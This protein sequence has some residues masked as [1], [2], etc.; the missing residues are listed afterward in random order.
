MRVKFIFTAVLICLCIGGC[1][2]SARQEQVKKNRHRIDTVPGMIEYLKGRHLPALQNVESWQNEYGPGLKLTTE[3]YEVYTTLLE[4]LMLSQVP[5]FVESC[6]R[7]YNDQ[8]LEP[9]ETQFKFTVYLF[10]KREQWESFTDSFAGEQMAPVYRK[11]K[12]GAYYLKGACVAYN[13]GREKTFSVLAHEGWHMFNSRFFRYQLPSWLDEGVAM[14]FE[15]NRQDG[16]FF[17]FEP[18]KNMYRLGGLKL[19]LANN[20]MIPLGEL[21][22]RNPGEV[23]LADEGDSVTAFYSQAYALVRFLREDDYGRNL[24]NYKRM[25]YDG[26]NG[27]WPLDDASRAIA[28][29]R[30]LPRTVVWN[31]YI[32]K[33][34]FT[35]YIGEDIRQ[36]EQDY[37]A[38][39]R[40]IVYH[41]RFSK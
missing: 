41:V 18:G 7:A 3:H 12:A 32:G 24:F 11:V 26:L 4:P 6:Y 34:I 2:E 25:L 36:I 21:I 8:M 9:I 23:L 28:I 15:Q 10:A 13:I 19:T 20:K 39:C 35:E 40:K 5:G 38:F 31:R 16:G 29:D 27:N 14:L 37:I 30:N 17:Y 1:Y 22:S 33:L